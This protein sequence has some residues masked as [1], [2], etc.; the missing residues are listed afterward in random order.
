METLNLALSDTS[1]VYSMNNTIVRVFSSGSIYL[2]IVVL[3]F[4]GCNSNTPVE[5]GN[6]HD[7]LSAKFVPPSTS[8]PFNLSVAATTDSGF[9]ISWQDTNQMTYLRRMQNHYVLEKSINGA[10]FSELATLAGNEMSFYDNSNIDTLNVYTYEIKRTSPYDT[11][12]SRVTIQYT[13]VDAQIVKTLNFGPSVGFLTLSSDGTMLAGEGDNYS[14]KVWRVGDYQLLQSLSDPPSDSL[15]F[16]GSAFV[17]AFSLD[18]KMIAANANKGPRLNVW[19]ISDGSRINQIY[20]AGVD[21]PANSFCFSNDGSK[22]ITGDG[23]GDIR[24]WDIASGTLEST[25]HVFSGTLSGATCSDWPPQNV[26]MLYLTRDGKDMILSCDGIQIRRSDDWSLVHKFN[27]LND[28]YSKVSF[29]EMHVTCNALIISLQ[30]GSVVQS[31]SNSIPELLSP[32][33]RAVTDLTYDHRFLVGTT[34]GGL[35]FV[36]QVSDQSIRFSLPNSH[37]PAIVCVPNS[38]E[39]LTSGGSSGEIDLWSLKFAWTSR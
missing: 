14:L 9:H 36:A 31:L 6:P 15:S 35:L 4:I 32:C 1:K 25:R 16:T 30:D 27:N 20:I 34:N 17:A 2:F 3:I 21:N 19:R 28:Y 22:I 12:I 5:Y 33:A 39:F 11:S 29:D 24:V 37:F 13:V 26:K 10:P 23:Y 7:P 38:H 8:A 18:G